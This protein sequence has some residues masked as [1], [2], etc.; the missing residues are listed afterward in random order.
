MTFLWGQFHKKYPVT[1][2]SWK[3]CL[4]FQSYHQPVMNTFINLFW[5]LCGFDKATVCKLRKLFL[6]RYFLIKPSARK[7]DRTVFTLSVCMYVCIYIIFM[8]AT[9]KN[10]V[11]KPS[12]HL[13]A[14]SFGQPYENAHDCVCLIIMKLCVMMS[15]NG[16]AF[17]TSVPLWGESTCLVVP[18]TKD[19]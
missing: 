17:H 4:K 1:K 15:W 8:S 18:L 16:N 3:I 19:Q 14:V 11:C 13:L 9:F 10:Q 12:M 5:H 7:I 6:P 2:I